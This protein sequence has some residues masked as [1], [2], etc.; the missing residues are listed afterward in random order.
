MESITLLRQVSELMEEREHQLATAGE[1][2]LV[3]W[4][5][6]RDWRARAQQIAMELNRLGCGW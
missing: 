2:R 5:W 6:R 4:Q 3:D 1:W